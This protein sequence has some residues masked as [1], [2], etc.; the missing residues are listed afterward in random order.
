MGENVIATPKS[1]TATEMDSG[2]RGLAAALLGALSGAAFLEACA[3][4]SSGQTDPEVLGRVAQAASGAGTIKFADTVADLRLITNGTSGWI[5]VL[6][7]Y[8]VKG[9]G[10]GGV[11]F[12]DTA[13]AVDDS[14]TFFNNIT[15]PSTA[16]GW[17]RIYVGAVNVK[18]F[19][20]AGNYIPANDDSI[21]DTTAITNAIQ[22]VQN[23]ARQIADVAGALTSNTAPALFFPAGVYKVTGAFNAPQT[24]IGDR[25]IIVQK[26]NNTTFQGFNTGPF[27]I[28]LRGIGCLEL[29][30]ARIDDGGEVASMA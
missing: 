11:F 23:A 2:R 20:A 3:A 22:A 1:Q 6:N 18:W 21:D 14:G 15:P 4:D 8:R 13:P 9:D 10:G 24:I 26:G 5:A 17:R 30:T 29:P 19:G 25:A 27:L 28:L 16:Q 7:G 12:W